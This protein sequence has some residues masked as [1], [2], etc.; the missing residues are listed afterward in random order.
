MAVTR[1][2]PARDGILQALSANHELHSAELA[3][4]LGLTQPPVWRALRQLE[5]E[6]KVASRKV[7]T[8]RLY[9]IG[10]GRPGSDPAP[11]LAARRAVQRIAL[12]RRA[13]GGGSDLP[14]L[15]KRRMVLEWW[16]A[17]DSALVRTKH[18]VVGGVAAAAYMPGR[19]TDDIDIAVAAPDAAMA[20]SELR[21]HGWKLVGQLDL[22]DGTVWRDA[23]GHELD[24]I[25]LHDPWADD[26]LVAAA[27]NRISELPTMPLPYLA[28]MKLKA[29]RLIDMGDL[30][31]MLG[32]ASR[33][34][35]RLT[36]GLVA[37][38][39]APQDVEDL[40][41]IILLGDLEVRG[42]PPSPR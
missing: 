12:R 15:M 10:P 11:R 23:E 42:E 2:T 20:E 36:R 31:R 25:S 18:A 28:L 8:I 29:G 14:G 24:L 33:G 1:R 30:S 35:R 4:Q 21:E 13:R 3:R 22:V 5:L 38:Y 27:K 17:A 9:R 40:D 26:A 6:G 32:L 19:Q 34:D 41:Q 37:K 16:H 7:G 39:G